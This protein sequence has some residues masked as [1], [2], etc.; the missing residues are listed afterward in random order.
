MPSMKD[1]NNM[2][3]YIIW[4]ELKDGQNM[5]LFSSEDSSNDAVGVISNVCML[6]TR[7]RKLLFD[8]CSF[9]KR[10]VK[11]LFYGQLGYTCLM[12]RYNLKES[13]AAARKKIQIKL[14]TGKLLHSNV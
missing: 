8:T 14:T 2:L 3:G 11:Y 12:S 7:V 10:I 5:V 9:R 6:E 1:E 4:Q 13:G